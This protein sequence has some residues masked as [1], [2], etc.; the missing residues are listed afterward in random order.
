MVCLKSVDAHAQEDVACYVS[1]R[2]LDRK[3]AGFVFQV[4]RRSA[5]L[6]H[7]RGYNRRSIALTTSVCAGL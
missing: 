4:D 6:H 2:D 5:T 1:T 3:T 7:D